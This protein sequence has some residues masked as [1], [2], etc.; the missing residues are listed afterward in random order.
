MV[1]TAGFCFEARGIMAMRR[2]HYGDVR[3]RRM[4]DFSSIPN[5]PD[6]YT[7]A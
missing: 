7:F 4:E 2:G 1:E 6:S 5:Y 3:A